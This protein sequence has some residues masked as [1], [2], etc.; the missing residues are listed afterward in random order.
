MILKVMADS[1]L[2]YNGQVEFN[3][4]CD[5]MSDSTRSDNWEAGVQFVN[6]EYDSVHTELDDT[7]AC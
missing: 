5:H 4:V 3:L 2:I 6:H 1:V 7:K